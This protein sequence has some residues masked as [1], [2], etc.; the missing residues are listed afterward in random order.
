MVKEYFSVQTIIKDGDGRLEVYESKQFTKLKK[1]QA[2]MRK[3]IEQDKIGWAY[4]Y[5][6]CISDKEGEFIRE[7][8]DTD[9]VGDFLSL[10]G[11]PN[12]CLSS[13]PSGK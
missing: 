2:Y 8:K 11:E 3:L 12:S 4:D 9:K 5:C 6:I 13:I 7:I 1:A 10:S